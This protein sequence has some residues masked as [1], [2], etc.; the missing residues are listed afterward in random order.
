ML[1]VDMAGGEYYF[2][3][4]IYRLSSVMQPPSLQIV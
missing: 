2:L 3:V 1:I 4:T